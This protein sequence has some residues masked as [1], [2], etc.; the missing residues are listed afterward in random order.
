VDESN[1]DSRRILLEMQKKYP[2]LR[3][4]FL[5]PNRKRTIADARNVSVLE[6]YGDYCLLHID[7]DDI[8]EPYISEFIKVFHCLEKLVPQ[9]ILLV[10]QQLNMG[11][12]DF[13]LSHGPYRNGA[14][15][16]DRDM[17]MRLAKVGAFFPMNHVPFF[18]RMPLPKK[19]EKMKALIR[20]YYSVRDGIRSGSNLKLFFSALIRNPGRLSYVTRIYNLLI[21]PLAS[22]NARILGA[23]DTSDYF[24]DVSEWNSY[25]V[26]HGGTFLEIAHRYDPSIS[27]DFLSAE[28][29]WLFSNKRYEKDFSDME[30]ELKSPIPSKVHV[31]NPQSDENTGG[32]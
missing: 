23:I 10:G 15:G 20:N 24:D 12:R 28:G 14:T 27:I 16:E 19:T 22:V 21:Y 32:S 11:K 25:K 18:H 2:N 6:S 1:D 30:D 17:W 13:L 8:W 31:D 29:K 26:E 9:E 4:I 7:C 5:E 3:T